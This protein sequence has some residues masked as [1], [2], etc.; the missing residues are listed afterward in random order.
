[1]LVILFG[2]AWHIM[3]PVRA[4]LQRARVTMDCKH[5]NDCDAFFEIFYDRT[6]AVFRA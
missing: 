1:M 6:L 4:M 2:M 3:D 5:L